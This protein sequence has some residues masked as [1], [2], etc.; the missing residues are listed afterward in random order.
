MCYPHFTVRT[1]SNHDGQSKFAKLTLHS[2]MKG[3]QTGMSGKKSGMGGNKY[4]TI[5]ERRCYRASKMM[6]I[7]DLKV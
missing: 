3:D 6:G 2:E 1:L 7:I 4:H 5:L